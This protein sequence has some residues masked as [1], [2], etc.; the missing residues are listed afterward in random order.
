MAFPWREAIEIVHGTTDSSQEQNATVAVAV[1]LPIERGNYIL[2]MNNKDLDLAFP[3]QGLV[4]LLLP[5]CDYYLHFLSHIYKISPSIIPYGGPS[6]PPL[7]LVDSCRG[8]L[9]F[10][11]AWFLP[12][13]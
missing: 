5:L 10:N 12:R 3:C 11:Q 1:V 13:G 7:R 9:G 2:V 8:N 4:A 6:T